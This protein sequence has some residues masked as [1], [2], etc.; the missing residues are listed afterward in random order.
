M[1]LVAPP[2]T[3]LH[4]AHGGAFQV[5]A[6]RLPDERRPVQTRPPGSSIRCLKQFGIQN[7]LNDFI[8]WS[9]LH[10]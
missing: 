4:L 8:L 10:N 9:L 5:L 3:S 7:Q 2:V 6:K 1:L